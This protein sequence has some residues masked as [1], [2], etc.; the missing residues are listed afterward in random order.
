MNQDASMGQ[1]R[2]AVITI[3]GMGAWG[4]HMLD[5]LPPDVV[6]WATL[7]AVHDDPLAL[8]TCRVRTLITLESDGEALMMSGTDPDPGC[9]YG[10]LLAAVAGADL[11]LLLGAQDEV[12]PP[13]LRDDF[14]I[15]CQDLGILT[16]L[17][18]PASVRTPQ[19]LEVNQGKM[20]LLVPDALDASALVSAFCQAI[21]SVILMPSVIGVDFADV[22][23][24]LEESGHALTS[25]AVASGDDRAREVA[26]AALD[27]DS[28]MAKVLPSARALM[29]VILSANDEIGLDEFTEIADWLN[30]FVAPEATVIIGAATDV[31][32]AASE[33][34][35]LLVASGVENL[36]R[37]RVS[38][39]AP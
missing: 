11:V 33:M 27:P 5:A 30:R 18:C 29:A 35:L 37:P 15:Q 6:S 26:L 9:G 13:R 16:V 12:M 23:T 22:R 28:E 32:L 4:C 25:F 20:T 7:V 21:C 10:R 3:M 14:V 34:K 24:V 1:A 36:P 2:C 39:S 8:A 17:V 19:S 31:D 38:G